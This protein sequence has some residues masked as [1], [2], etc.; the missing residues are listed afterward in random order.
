MTLDVRQILAVLGEA[1]RPSLDFDTMGV[2][3]FEPGSPEFMLFG[4]VGE[5]PVA[6]VARLSTLDY[7]VAEAVTGGPPGPRRRDGDRTRPPLRGRSRPARRRPALL[8][9]G[10]DALRRRGPGRAPVRKARGLLVRRR[11]RRGRPRS[12]PSEWSLES[13][14][15]GWPRSSAGWR[16]WSAAP[17]A[18]AEP[19]E[20]P[21]RATS[22]V[23]VR[24]DHRPVANSARS[25][26]PGRAGGATEATV[27]ITGESGTGKELVARA[28]HHASRRRGRPVRGGQLRGAARAPCS[29]PSCSATCAAPSPARAG[30]RR[31]VRAGGRRHA[32]PRRDRRALRRPPGQAPPRAPGAASTRGSGGTAA[33]R[34]TSRLVAA[35]NRDL[36]G[37][38]RA[39]R[40]RQDLFY[41]LNVVR[42]TCRRCASAADDACS[43]PDNFLRRLGGQDGKTTRR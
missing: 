6:S 39:G 14:T 35:T 30:Q 2:I 36:D 24:A 7:S 19:E 26:H 15:S 41:R 42:V 13:S 32:L 37:R 16:P 5:P 23:R 29:R 1:I 17:G 25:A 22:A 28:I 27:L 11:G 34:P 21:Q 20:R 40:F 38:D 18:G 43:S 4:T 12:S 33:P 3:L 10:S 9:V 31:A 8:P